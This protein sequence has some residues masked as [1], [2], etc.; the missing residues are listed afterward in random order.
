LQDSA[1]KRIENI[2]S[3]KLV[4]YIFTFARLSPRPQGATPVGFG[5]MNLE[6]TALVVS[7][8][9]VVAKV[10]FGLIALSGQLS[11]TGAAAAAAA[12]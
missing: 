1:T 8:I 12:D 2:S 9:D 7:Y 5:F 10:G 11:I 3:P 4:G 6:T